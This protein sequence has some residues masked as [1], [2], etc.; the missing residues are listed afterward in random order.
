MNDQDG[1]QLPWPVFLSELIGTALLVLVGLSLVIFMFGSGT[2]MAR[3]IPSE[4][5]RRLDHGIFLW[6]DGCADR[7]VP[8]RMR[9][10][11]HVNPPACT[12]AFRLM[13]EFDLKTTLGYIAAQA[14]RRGP[15]GLAAASVGKHGGERRVR[16]DLAG[17]RHYSHDGVSGRSNGHRCDGCLALRLSRF[18]RNPALHPGDLPPALRDHGVGRIADLRHQHQP[19]A[20]QRW[21][22]SHIP[23][24]RPGWW[25]YWIGPMAGMLLAVLAC[26]FLAKRIEVAKLYY[27]E[28]D[29]D[30][31]FRRGLRQHGWS[32]TSS[33]RAAE[34]RRPGLTVREVAG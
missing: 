18:P 9:S 20:R 26:S 30:R 13:G 32:E 7:A 33:D 1:G 29:K 17:T 5:L 6:N 14:D 11:A 34:R 22:G 3:L 10:G 19:R 21:P 12:L 2:P 31:L 16:R 23:G 25:V 4:D 24:Y 8:A 27:F 28:S 15:G